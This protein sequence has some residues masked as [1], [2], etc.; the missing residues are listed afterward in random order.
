MAFGF[1]SAFASA[2]PNQYIKKPVDKE[3]QLRLR[4]TLFENFVKFKRSYEYMELQISIRRTSKGVKAGYQEGQIIMGAKVPQSELALWSANMEPV[5][6]PDLM[7]LKKLRKS[8]LDYSKISQWYQSNTVIVG[9]DPK[10]SVIVYYDMAYRI[11]PKE[12]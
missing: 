11:G 9:L 6:S 2:T 1:F 3:K 8:K 7:F 5:D 10:N 12:E 4:V